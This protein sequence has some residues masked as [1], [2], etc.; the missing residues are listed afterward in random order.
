MV[1]LTKKLRYCSSTK[2]D[3]NNNK[4]GRG[5]SPGSVIILGTNTYALPK[6]KIYLSD[7]L[8]I[9][10]D[11]FEVNA[12]LPPRGI[13]IGI[14]AQYYE[15]HNMSYTSQSKNNIPRNHA[16]QAIKYKYIWILILGIK[17]LELYQKDLEDISSKQLTGK[18]K[19]VHVIKSRRDQNNFR[20]NL[21]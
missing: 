6:L 7:N 8:L 21:Q 3:E 12:N 17:E 2:F 19:K 11:I 18:C 1:V 14:V 9:K 16:F 13:P 15:Y 4:F 5:W 20:T 10:Y